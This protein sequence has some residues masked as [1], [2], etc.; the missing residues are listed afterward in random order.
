[1]AGI[2]VPQ[3]EIFKIGTGKLKNNNWD[4]T[5]TKDE[6]FK[7]QELVPLFEGQ[8]FR[9]MANKIINKKI[10]HIDFS[11]IFVQIVIEQLGDF[12]RAVSNK[13][14]IINGIA[15]KRFVGTTGGLK[16]STLLFCNA[17]YLDKLNFLCECKRNPA[18]KLNPAK[19]EAYKSLTCSASQPIWRNSSPP[20]RA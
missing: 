3:Y 4:I 6:A 20:G 17:D 9:I 7:R 18:V 13:G 2:S 12:P 16:N 10:F 8:E 1:M 5:I 15:F 19:Y 14:I 11:C